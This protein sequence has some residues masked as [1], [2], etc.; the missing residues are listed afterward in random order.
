MAL[1]RDGDRYLMY[2][3]HLWHRGWSVLDVTQPRS[4]VVLRFIEGPENTWTGQV[5]ASEDYLL[6][7]LEEIPTGW[8]GDSE[9]P[10]KAGVLL[11]SLADPAEPRLLQEYYVDGKGTHRN[12]IDNQGRAH[13]SINLAGKSGRCY[14]VLDF[15]SGKAPDLLGTFE[16]A[17][18]KEE[19]LKD[20]SI[21][22]HGPP[23][24]DND[25]VY[26]SYGGAGVVIAAY[27]QTDGF[28]EIGRLTFSPPFVSHIGVHSVLPLEG[29]GLLLACSE[30][31]Q[32]DCLE[33]L[34]HVSLIDASDP[35]HPYLVS[36]FPV[37]QPSGLEGYANYCEKGGR[38]GP[39]NLHMHQHNLGAAEI[40]SEVYATYFNAGLR[41]FNIR[42]PRSPR[43]EAFFVPPDPK[44]RY[45]T[46]PVSRLVAQSEDVIV[47]DRGYIFVSHKNQGIWCL[48]RDPD[49]GLYT[50]SL[51]QGDDSANSGT[52]K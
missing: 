28:T 20:E 47:D 1:R 50:D 6:T 4:P 19:R 17:E 21:S 14:Q 32:E 24:P 8:G 3:G 51:P 44:R 49:L 36:V 45:G 13:L 43:E 7:G 22:L 12:L 41:V 25:L 40:G 31:I 26:L 23:I 48:E 10:Y 5:D 35:R 30:A 42:D 9:R 27:S 52:D 39:H 34:G 29:G 38:F 33:P 18:Q 2:T 37:P 16:I 11:W 15:A 46:H